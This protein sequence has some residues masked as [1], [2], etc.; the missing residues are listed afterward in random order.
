M[1][2]SDRLKKKDYEVHPIQLL[3]AQELVS[4]NHYAKGGSNTATFIHGLFRRDD[5]WICL[6]VAWWIPPTRSCAEFIHPP[7][8]QRVLA[9]SRL[10]VI[11]GVPKNAAS[12]L[13][14]QSVKLIEADGRWEKLVTYAD[15]WQG[16]TGGIY[17]ATNWAFEGMTKRKPTWLDQDGR[18]ISMK[19]GGHTRTNAEMEGLG[20]RFQGY[21]SRLRF[22]KLLH[23]RPPVPARPLATTQPLFDIS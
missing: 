10:I 15:T 1:D 17:R 18:M 12:F 16:H 23:P 8:W 14:A 7:A 22:T 3:L 5:P 4:L 20:Y 9:L 13:I 6:G 2:Y 21:F 11:P 19:A